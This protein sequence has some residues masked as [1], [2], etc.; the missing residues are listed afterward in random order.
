LKVSA[1]GTRLVALLAASLLLVAPVAAQ[2]RA[3]KSA[4]PQTQ[5]ADKLYS[6]GFFA[7]E[8]FDTSDKAPESFRQVI[9][10]YPR[11]TAAESAQFFLGS[12]YQRKYQLELLN[13]AHDVDALTEAKKAFEG[14]IAKYPKDSSC[15][16]LSDAY[17]NLALVYFQLGNP[18]TA[19]TQ[20]AKINDSY[21]YDRLIYI[22]QVVSSPN[23]KDVIDSH[24][25]AVRLANY[26]SSITGMPF[27]TA[28]VL[29][30]RWCTGER[31]K[32]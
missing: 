23:Q 32:L 19:R 28:V 30:R 17:F 3:S 18:A 13:G 10:K 29:L 8:N 21:A 1:H 22:Y 31:G 14:Y 15:Q 9:K 12:F 27:D 16:C 7:Y 4:A 25:D 6:Q 20:L 24:F 11:T 5:D 26:T 2:K